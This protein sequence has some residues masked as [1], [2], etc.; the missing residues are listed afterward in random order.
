MSWTG[1]E[2]IGFER[3]DHIRLIKAIDGIGR[4]PEGQA[5]SVQHA[6]AAARLILMPLSLGELLKQGMKLRSKRGRR[7]SFRQD[8]QPVPL[9][10]N[11]ER[12]FAIAE[13]NAPQFVMCPSKITAW[14]RSG[15][16]KIQN[17]SLR[18]DIRA[19]QAAGMRRVPLEFSWAVPMWLSTSKPVVDPAKEND[20]A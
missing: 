16:I 17:G 3:N 5:R 13:V 18:K 19:A 14:E 9:G 1:S 2:E 20:V 12:A 7:N 4:L 11:C 6:I 15:I 8:A 10:A